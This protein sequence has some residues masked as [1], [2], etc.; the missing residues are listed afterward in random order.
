[1]SQITK[2]NL[3][4]LGACLASPIYIYAIIY[5]VFGHGDGHYYMARLL[6]ELL[7]VSL[8][9]GFV[10]FSFDMYHW[11]MRTKSD[12]SIFWKLSATIWALVLVNPLV[13]FVLTAIALVVSN[14][15]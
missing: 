12:E 4:I 5:I 11:Q 7:G 13:T 14:H 1:M 3:G 8:V 2:R 15:G 10:G 9:S 6:Y